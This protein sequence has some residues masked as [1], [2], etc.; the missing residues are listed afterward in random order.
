MRLLFALL[1]ACLTMPALAAPH[2]LPA[3]AVALGSH[4]AHHGDHQPTPDTALTMRGDDCIGCIAPIDGLTRLLLPLRLSA[5]SLHAAG[6]PRNA[7]GL[8]ARPATP[9]PRTLG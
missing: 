4:G 3:P 8:T 9:P 7:D 6:V 2:C 5:P 1:I